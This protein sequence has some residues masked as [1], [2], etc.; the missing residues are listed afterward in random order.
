MTTIT[1]LMEIAT[2]S[3]AIEKERLNNTSIFIDIARFKSI[4]SINH[5]LGV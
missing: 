2:L 4:Q 3:G 1:A 5:A